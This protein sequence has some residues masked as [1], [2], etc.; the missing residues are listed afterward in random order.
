MSKNRDSKAGRQLVLALRHD[1]GTLGLVLDVQ[2]YASVEDVLRGLAA[3]GVAL[4]RQDLEHIVETSDKKRFAFSADGTMI[5]ASQG[6]SVSVELGYEAEEPPVILY[7][8]TATH[9][10]EGIERQGLVRGS[11]HHVHLSAT[12]GVALKV[13]AR[14]GAPVVLEVEAARMHC[15]GHAFYR[16]ANGVWLTLHVP[17][18]FLKRPEGYR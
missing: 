12:Q 10:L 13:G 4:S 9:F 17:V 8:G 14:H 18:A 6:H 16:A 7:H 2:G 1:P 3:R 5:R 15:D 11:R